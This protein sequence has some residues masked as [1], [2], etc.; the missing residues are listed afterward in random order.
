MPCSDEG[1]KGSEDIFQHEFGEGD[2]LHEIGGAEDDVIEFGVLE[3][4][5]LQKDGRGHVQ[6]V[7]DV[8]KIAEKFRIGEA[9]FPRVHRLFFDVVALIDLSPD[10]KHTA[11]IADFLQKSKC[12]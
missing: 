7:A 3:K 10:A 12:V 9:L 5:R 11:I 4:V 8:G 6:L 1:G 2:F